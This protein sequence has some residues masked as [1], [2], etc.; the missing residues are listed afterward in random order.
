MNE[1]ISG[2]Y[3]LT[4]VFVKRGSALY[5]LREDIGENENLAEV[6]SGL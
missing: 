5:N 4:E 3:P 6:I 2:T 1:A